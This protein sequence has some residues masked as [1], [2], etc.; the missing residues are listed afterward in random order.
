MKRS[1]ISNKE[2]VVLKEL[3]KDPKG[4][5]LLIYYGVMFA[6]KLFTGTETAVDL[7]HKL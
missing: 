2:N 5:E 4:N 3:P 7:I 1:C 6:D